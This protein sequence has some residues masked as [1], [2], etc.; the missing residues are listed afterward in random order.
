M[1]IEGNSGSS[2]WKV[3]KA[4]GIMAVLYKSKPEVI[5]AIFLIKLVRLSS[6]NYFLRVYN[7]SVSGYKRNIQKYIDFNL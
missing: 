5:V 7:I 4:M 6:Y 2:C 1:K 3:G